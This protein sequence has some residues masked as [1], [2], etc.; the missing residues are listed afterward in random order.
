MIFA[1]KNGL[2]GATINFHAMIICINNTGTFAKER[3]V[4]RVIGK[5]N[6]RILTIFGLKNY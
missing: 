2:I 4:Y 3:I 6:G 1:H 5:K